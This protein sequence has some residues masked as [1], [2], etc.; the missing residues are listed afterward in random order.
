VR[1]GPLARRVAAEAIGTAFLLATIV[2]S[3]IM[4]ERLCSGND[5]LAL[6]CNALATGAGLVAMILAL[7]PVSGGHFNPVVTLADAV[8]GG[9]AWKEVPAYAAAQV[10][11]AVLGVAIADL[12]FALPV[13]TLSTHE[14]TGPGQWLAE[15]VAT[16]GLL[17]T[18][19]GVSRRTP[20]A[21]PIAVSAYIVSAYW[22]TA[23]TSFANPAVTLARALTDTFAGI[24]IADVPAFVLAQV[25]GAIAAT[26]VCRWLVPQAPA[27]AI[28]MGAS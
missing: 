17:A 2:G 19:F 28:E 3:G 10:A 27:P 25:A 14:R 6:L 24:R 8:E 4:A 23:S 16:F 18:I 7:G 5:G 21:T 9:L 26:L 1:V 15:A 20:T 22:F 13:F 12:M 11:G